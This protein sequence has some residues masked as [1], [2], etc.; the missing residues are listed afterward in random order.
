MDCNLKKVIGIALCLGKL[1]KNQ[2]MIVSLF[3]NSLDIFLLF[4]KHFVYDK[5]T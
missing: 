5:S 4:Y 3:E 2:I 1:A